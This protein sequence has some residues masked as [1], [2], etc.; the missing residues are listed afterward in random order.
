MLMK[1]YCAKPDCLSNMYVFMDNVFTL[2]ELTEPTHICWKCKRG[3]KYSGFMV[4]G[5]LTE[6]KS[7]QI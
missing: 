3:K 2:Y 6:K 1:K 4:M 5:Q 7:L